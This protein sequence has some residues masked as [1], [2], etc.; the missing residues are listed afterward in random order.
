LN[1]ECGKLKVFKGTGVGRQL[2]G[3]KGLNVFPV[4][5]CVVFSTG[6]ALYL[7]YIINHFNVPW[8]VLAM[9]KLQLKI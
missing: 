7:P 1:Y 6:L 4:P 2:P 5:V 8:P 3:V 9:D